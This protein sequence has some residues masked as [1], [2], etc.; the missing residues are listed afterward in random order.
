MKTG[1]LKTLEDKV[2]SGISMSKLRYY[3]H[4]YK[5]SHHTLVS[6]IQRRCENCG[7]FIS[8]LR[9]K[10]CPN[11]TTKCSAHIN[12]LKHRQQRIDSAAEYRKEHPKE[13]KSYRHKHYMKV[14]N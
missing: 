11:C 3:T 1:D 6:W 12:Y 7:R 5:E 8:K 14:G 4:K 10:Y 9:R 13:Y 2:Y